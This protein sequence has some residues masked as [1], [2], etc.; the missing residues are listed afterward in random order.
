MGLLG[1][2][3]VKM[4]PIITHFGLPLLADGLDKL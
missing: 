1:L 2:L 4:G 3:W